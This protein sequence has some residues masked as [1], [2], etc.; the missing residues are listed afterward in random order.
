[1]LVTLVFEDALQRRLVL[2]ARA[3]EV[4]R[5]GREIRSPTH[6]PIDRHAGRDLTQPAA[7]GFRRAQL[8]DLQ[9]R[10]DEDFL[11]QFLGLGVITHTA[12]RDREDMPLIALEQLAKRAPVTRLS[13]DDELGYAQLIRI[14]DAHT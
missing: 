8:R 10:L 1:A 4:L 2:V 14:N 11:D 5:R 9:H 6:R 13:S 7:E 12:Q 3:I